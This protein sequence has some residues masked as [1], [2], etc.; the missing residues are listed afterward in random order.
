MQIAKMRVKVFHILSHF[1]VGGA[2]KIAINIA[3]SKSPEI[4]Y[5]IVE[6]IRSRTPFS[7]VFVREMQDAGIKYHRAFFPEIEFHYL[8]ERIASLVFP[9]WFFFVFRKYR[10]DVLH[11][12]T[13]ITE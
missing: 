9:L 6:V 8:F 12:H 10:P 3:K 11:C 4:E 5:H 7:N 1:D 13:E 2:E